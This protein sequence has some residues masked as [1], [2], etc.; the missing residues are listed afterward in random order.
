MR[1]A[2]TQG[3]T[4]ISTRLIRISPPPQL[5]RKPMLAASRKGEL[6]IPEDTIQEIFSRHLEDIIRLS[7]TLL[8]GL[9]ERLKSWS[10]KQLIGDVM[11][12][13]VRIYYLN[14]I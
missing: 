2:I 5:F 14:K 4:I 11:N 7:R 8:I 1:L 13:L 6:D 3:D 9:R 12:D 10:D